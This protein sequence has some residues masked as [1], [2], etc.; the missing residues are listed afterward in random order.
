[1]IGFCPLVCSP[2]FLESPPLL[3]AARF[4][5]TKAALPSLPNF[6]AFSFD[7]QTE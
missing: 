1:L 3:C 4:L 5:F 2:P 6:S 7:K